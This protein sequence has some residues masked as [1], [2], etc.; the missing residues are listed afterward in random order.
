MYF[1]QIKKDFETSNLLEERLSG[2]AVFI[3]KGNSKR[4]I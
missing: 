3:T 4:G 1:F 2:K